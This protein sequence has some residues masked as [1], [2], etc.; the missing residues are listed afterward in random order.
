MLI[1]CDSKVAE[2]G[3]EFWNMPLSDCCSTKPSLAC[4]TLLWR[5]MRTNQVLSSPVFASLLLAFSSFSYLCPPTAT[6]ANIAGFAPIM[7]PFVGVLTVNRPIV[8]AREQAK[9]IRQYDEIWRLVQN[10]FLYR[11]RLRNWSRWR[12]RFDYQLT[13]PQAMQT[14]VDTMLGSLHDPYTYY[15]NASATT[16]RNLEDSETKVVDYRMINQKVGYIKLKTFCSKNCVGEMRNGMQQLQGAESIVMDLRDNKGGSIDDAFR[17]FSMFVKSGR[18][19][20]MTGIDKKAVVK[21]RLTVSKTKLVDSRGNRR[22]TSTISSQSR[23]PNMSKAR[24]LMILVDGRTKSAAEMLAGALRDS[25]G[26]KLIGTKTYGK[27]VIQRV[28][29]FDN[30]TSIKVTSAAY[31]LPS[32]ATIHGVGIKPAIKVL[33]GKSDKQ[34]QLATRLLRANQAHRAKSNSQH[35]Q[36]KNQNIDKEHV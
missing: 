11:N 25:A 27:G 12:H 29:Q 8:D 33:S 5:G 7:P 10:S 4:F 16:T 35:S 31:L 36:L 9:F 14:A 2:L 3:I 17:I 15:R 22:G 34:L 13:S 23:E 21:E 24:P 19:V 26:A 30:N 28:W 1:F 20:S 18:F 32:G 6:S